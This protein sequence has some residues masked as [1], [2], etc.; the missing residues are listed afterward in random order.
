MSD[1]SLHYGDFALGRRSTLVEAAYAAIKAAIRNGTFPPGFQGSELEISQR[2]GMSRTPV[3]QAIIQL[4][5]EGMVDLRSKRGVVIRALSPDDMR[6]VYDV[7]VAVEGMAAFIIASL[8]ASEREAI[9]DALEE[10]NAA[11]ERALEADDLDAW[12]DHDGKFH[13]MLVERSG[14]GRL[15]RIATVNLD[16]SHR[17]R[18]VTLNLRPKPTQSVIEHRAI[19]DAMR[20]GDAINCRVA[21]QKHKESARDIVVPLL[22]RYR[23]THL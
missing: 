17:A 1:A 4:Q 14:N 7:I 16:Q 22:R 13:S 15:E 3:H 20:R 19:I 18:R 12:A 2:L 8:P 5:A 21:A 11:M 10:L 6:E 23:M 9:C